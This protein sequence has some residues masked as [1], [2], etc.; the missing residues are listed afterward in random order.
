VLLLKS[1]LFSIPHGHAVP[2]SINTPKNL[3]RRFPQLVFKSDKAIASSLHCS[4]GAVRPEQD[5]HVTAH[6]THHVHIAA[7]IKTSNNPMEAQRLSGMDNQ[8]DF[9]GAEAGTHHETLGHS[10]PDVDLAAIRCNGADQQAEWR[11]PPRQHC[12]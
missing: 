2:T 10:V 12:L 4:C 8:E 6:V 9:R 7:H 3:S 11:L 5:G 1:A